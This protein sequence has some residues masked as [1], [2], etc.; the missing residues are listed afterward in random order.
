MLARLEGGGITHAAFR[1]VAY[2]EVCEGGGLQATL[3][4]GE[5]LLELIVPAL[6]EGVR[7]VAFKQ[8]PRR[9]NAPGFCSAG[10]RAELDAGGVIAQ[11]CLVAALSSGPPRRCEQTAEALV[12]QTLTEC[13]IDSTM[14]VLAEELTMP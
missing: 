1:T 13:T 8:G 5:I 12:G 2:G 14:K 7:V 9:T 3:Q 11:F 6:S 4:P 10:A